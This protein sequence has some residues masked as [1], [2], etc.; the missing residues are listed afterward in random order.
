MNDRELFRL[1]ELVP[2]EYTEET[3]EFLKI[4]N[5]DDSTVSPA[6]V[7]RKNAPGLQNNILWRILL[8]A[9]AAAC[10]AVLIFAGIRTGL[11]EKPVT[12]S[13]SVPEM[14]AVAEQTG[15]APAETSRTDAAALYTETVTQTTVRQES[16]APVQHGTTAVT[17]AE[18]RQSADREQTAAQTAAAQEHAPAPTTT[19]AP[20]PQP[21]PRYQPG[22]VNMDG[23]VDLDDAQLLYKEYVA[24]VV[25]GGE[26]ILTPQQ[27]A[28]GDVYPNTKDDNLVVFRRRLSSSARLPEEIIMTDYPISY[29][30]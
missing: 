7:I 27:I 8:P 15:T 5:A 4:H 22:D 29:Q 10:F 23:K 21:E 30:D 19:D 1:M 14:T 16:T 26:S 3:A 18:S 2:E 13:S 25:E 11:H 9:G 17:A 6:P 28:L 12:E 20:A 24:V